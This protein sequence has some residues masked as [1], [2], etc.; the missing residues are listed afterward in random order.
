[1]PQ[2]L[3]LEASCH[4]GAIQFRSNPNFNCP[5]ANPQSQIQDPLSVLLVL[6]LNL[7][8][9][10]RE[11]RIWNQHCSRGRSRKILPLRHREILSNSF[12][13][14]KNLKS[15]KPTLERK[16]SPA[17]GVKIL[18]PPIND[19]GNQRHFCPE[20]GSHLYAYDERWPQWIYPY[21]SCID[22]PLPKPEKYTYMC[23]DSKV[24]WVEVPEGGEH[25]QR[26]PDKGIED[27]HK[28]EGLFYG[29]DEKEE[30]KPKKQ[31]ISKKK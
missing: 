14:K 20:C 9:D 10:K 4:C 19:S 8:Q 29:G 13:G 12:R 5:I 15:T 22:T 21:P 1:M 25:F 23:L 28:A 18:E 11:R 16:P 17:R 6:L 27:W 2:P 3:Q 31:N 26:Y 24:S 7:P 30:P